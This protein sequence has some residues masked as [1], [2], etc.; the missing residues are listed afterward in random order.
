MLRTVSRMV[1][2]AGAT[3]LQTHFHP[4]VSMGSQ[5]R[6][7]TA[8][9]SRV[10]EAAHDTADCAQS[11]VVMLHRDVPPDEPMRER[12]DSN[13]TF[14]GPAPDAEQ[15]DRKAQKKAAKA[16]RRARREGRAPHEQGQKD[17]DLCSKGVD[18]LIRCRIDET[19]QWKMVCGKC[20]KGVSGG[21][22]DGDKDHPHYQYGGLWKKR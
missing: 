10:G 7:C 9:A 12:S 5:A 1:I 19:R 14:R 3:G 16:A 18:L 17:C 4:S 6:S 13:G 11:V 21:V 22:T 20:W 2:C 15:R 8:F